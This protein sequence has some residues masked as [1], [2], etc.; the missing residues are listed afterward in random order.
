[1]PPGGGRR[2]AQPRGYA[3]V[4]GVSPAHATSS[5]VAIPCDGAKLAGDLALPDGALAIV[6]FAHGSGSSRHSPRNRLVAERLQHAGLATLLLDLLTEEEEQRDLRTRQLRFDV[7]L[8][9]HRLLAAIDWLGQQAATAELPVG[10]FGASTGAAGALIAA[11]QRPRRVR[12]VVSRGG[13]P[14]LAGNHLE[15]VAAPTLLIVGGA[16]HVVL[17][18][19]RQAQM[20][21]RRDTCL[22]MIEG[23]SHLFEE[24]GALEDVA[25]LACDWFLSHLRHERGVAG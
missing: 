8:L 22:Y 13:R 5:S 24:P 4:M 12:A 21:L 15:S 1:M 11:A 10:C 19:N 17:E 9:S 2:C 25:E 20:R 7:A 6:V 23:A 18:L 14:D 3:K 16:D